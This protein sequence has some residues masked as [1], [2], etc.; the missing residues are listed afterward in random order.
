MTGNPRH[1]TNRAF[2][3]IEILVA[4]GIVLILIAILLPVLAGARNAANSAACLSNIRSLTVDYTDYCTTTPHMNN[5]WLY[6]YGMWLTELAPLIG[7][8]GSTNIADNSQPTS[9]ITPSIQKLAICPSTSLPPGFTGG[10]TLATNPQSSNCNFESF[11]AANVGGSTY[12][13]INPTV[14]GGA[15]SIPNAYTTWAVGDPALNS[16]TSGISNWIFGSYGFNAW[17]YN[18]YNIGNT[19]NY[20]IGDSGKTDIY[21]PYNYLNNPFL[22]NGLSNPNQFFNQVASNNGNNPQYTVANAYLLT[23][24]DS[25]QAPTTET[26]VFFDSAWMEAEPTFID[27]P[28]QPNGQ[29]PAIPPLQPGNTITSAANDAA[30]NAGVASVGLQ[31]LGSNTNNGMYNVCINRHNMSVNVGFA[32]GHAENVSLGNLWTLNWSATPPTP[33][34]AAQNISAP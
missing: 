31:N 30:S 19:N 14:A 20:Y 24:G 10:A 7:N 8:P 9:Y 26:P 29:A 15:N 34:G 13:T 11:P 16:N 17:L 18:G 25:G 27:P 12:N 22:S 3:L 2:T 33:A 23:W 6:D 21:A 28:A 32:D 1:Q 5:G 4:L